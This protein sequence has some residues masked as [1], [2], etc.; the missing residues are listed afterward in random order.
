M[1]NEQKRIQA[2]L[3]LRLDGAE[4]W[5]IVETIAAKEQAGEEPWTV[6]DGGQPATRAEISDLIDAADRLIQQSAPGL[7]AATA[8]QLA[9]QRN[10]YARCIQACEHATAARILKSIA[11]IEQANGDTEEDA[12]E[13]REREKDLLLEVHRRHLRVLE[14]KHPSGE[15]FEHGPLWSATQ[16]FEECQDNDARRMHW[17]RTM[18]GLIEAG[19]VIANQA[20]GCRWPN[21]RL[22]DAGQEIVSEL[23]AAQEPANEKGE[24]TDGQP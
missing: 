2:V 5:D 9:M 20:E 13:L 17:T 23:L 15:L 16:W 6:E 11:A 10:L 18:K 21:V 7:P 8:R 4:V 22:S 1:T 19:L 12:G 24:T 3:Q 14:T